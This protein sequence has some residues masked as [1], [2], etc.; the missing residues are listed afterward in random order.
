MKVDA[1]AEALQPT[2]EDFINDLGQ[3][4]EINADNLE[5]WA[6]KGP[7]G[8]E[9]TNSKFEESVRRYPGESF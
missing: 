5:Y 6:K 1:I 8:C 7:K 3:C 9:H 4:G 2:L